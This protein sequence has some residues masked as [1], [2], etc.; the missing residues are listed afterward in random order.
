MAPQC[1]ENATRASRTCDIYSSYLYPP[2]VRYAAWM[3]F[4][5]IAYI[6]ADNSSRAAALPFLVLTVLRKQ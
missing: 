5:L 1:G 3:V 6:C 4:R 2:Q